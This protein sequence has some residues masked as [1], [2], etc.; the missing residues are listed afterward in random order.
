[1]S[2]AGV[3]SRPAWAVDLRER[4]EEQL[5]DAAL[6]EHGLE[7]EPAPEGK[8]IERIVIVTNDVLLGSDFRIF[9]RVPVLSHFRALN[10]LHVRTRQYIV[11][12]ELL[13]RPGDRFRRDLFEESGRNLRSMFILA[14]ARLVAAKGSTPDDVI[15]VVVTKDQWT[16]RLNSNF[17]IDQ[18]RLDGLSFSISESNLAGRNKTAAL[19][20]AVDP[21]RILLGAGYVDPRVWSSRHTYTVSGGLY[22]NRASS[23]LEG[24]YAN[25]SV[26]RPLFSLR[27]RWAWDL[28]GGYSDQIVRNFAGGQLRG[29]CIGTL[30]MGTCSGELLPFVYTARLWSTELAATRSWGIG[31]KL[32]LRFGWRV[33]SSQYGLT[34]EVQATASPEAQAIFRRNQV[35]RSED[36]SGPFLSIDAFTAD[37]VRLQNIHTF[38]LTEDFR[39]GPRF[40]AEVRW[41]DPAFGFDN[42]FFAMAGSYSDA[43]YV[44]DDLFAMVVALGARVQPGVLP[45]HVLVNQ[46]VSFS[47]RNISP[48]FGPFRFHARASLRMRGHDLAN[49]QLLLGSSNG[50]RPF[51]P[52]AFSGS[53]LYTVNLELRT[54]PLNLWTL[55]VGAV[56]FYDGG[57]APPTLLQAGWHHGMGVG[58]RIL[59]PQ[60]NRDVLRLDLA[61][62][63][64]YENVLGMAG[65]VIGQAW[66]PRFSA[67]FGQAF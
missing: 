55:H 13:F 53:N 54:L 5:I 21:G 34:P 10:R 43:R 46:D 11:R 22:L 39:L 23:A 41:S 57:D 8:R 48:R 51:S 18:V 20:I 62:P 65:G 12:Q 28:T 49:V 40:S 15:V 67:E 45:G 47:V 16:L 52:R 58:L 7:V 66:A 42:R 9:D 1:M 27:T 36:A 64:E 60:F 35:P 37:F 2:L 32:N 44:R 26:G 24:F 56:L 50:L 63:F 14:V 33:T 19:N 38:A 61:F 30:S 31:T 3:A 59:I 6:A 25:G 17:V 29:V 4:Y